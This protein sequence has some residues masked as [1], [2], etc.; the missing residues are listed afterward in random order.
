MFELSVHRLG[1]LLLHLSIVGCV[2]MVAASIVGRRRNDGRLLL[3]GERAGYAVTGA[4]LASAALLVHSFLSHDY[5]NKYVAHYSDNNMPWYYLIASFWGGQAGSLMFWATTLAVVT[6]IVIWQNREQN[7]DIL[8][9]VIASLGTMQV[10]FL[11]LMVREANPFDA[12]LITE[13]PVNGRGLEPLLQ[14]PA[15]TFHP[16]SILSGYVWFSVPFAFAIASLVHRRLDDG[17]IR[18]TRRYAVVSWA[19]LSIGNLF[20]GM[21]AYQ[22]L[23][24]GGF[25][26]WD[27]VENAALMPWISATAYLHSVMIQERRGLLKVWNMF[28]VF[29]TGF[30][31]LFGTFLTRAGVID[32]VHTFAQSDVGD[33]F[34]GALAVVLVFTH[35]LLVA[36]VA[37]GSLA[38]GDDPARWVKAYEQAGA[39]K[40]QLAVGL[41]VGLLV[42][43]YGVLAFLSISQPS[44]EL[45]AG[46][47]L[48]AAA[49]LSIF[50]LPIFI[51]ITI[52]IRWAVLRTRT[53]ANAT[54][55][56]DL[57][58]RE[59]IFLLN[60][61][62]LISI[63]AV[64]MFG[65]I[66]EK[67]SEFFWQPT[68][69]SA[70]WYNAWIAPLGVGLILLMGVGPLVP[71][72]RMSLQAFRKNLLSPAIFAL[73]C[74]GLIY[75]VNLYDLQKHV[76]ETSFPIGQVPVG[77]LLHASK[78]T[79][80]YT[81]LGFYGVFFSVLTLGLEFFRGA[82]LRMKSTSESFPVA[83]FGLIAKGRRR[84]GGYMAHIGFA[85][86]FLGF[87]GTGLKT[88][89]DMSFAAEGTTHVIRD[90]HLTFTGF[91][92]QENREYEEWFAR[93][94][95]RELNDDGTAGE[96]IGVLFPS[97]RF[98]NGA[99]V[100]LSR[101][102]TEKDELHAFRGNLYLALVSFRPGFKSCEIMAHFNP[103]IVWMWIG[104][105]LLLFGVVLSIWPEP[106]PYPVF[107]AA[108]RRARKAAPATGEA[109]PAIGLAAADV[110][111]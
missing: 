13:P 18:T 66:G 38:P 7:R 23:G 80:V 74:V 104:G 8:P 12:F 102:T 10:F 44:A 48:I 52:L 85:G 20:G 70:P 94:E 54:G 59:G 57:A 2:F 49:F 71:W 79:G 64:V 37:D 84:Y 43:V 81:L 58:S 91:D 93:F 73:A 69:Y 16:P 76:A 67:V 89:V 96:Q 6:G 111:R 110:E 5:Q 108:R 82:R 9:T 53:P 51:G 88:E 68:K 24:W 33:Y 86:L 63:L 62:I 15:M 14:N 22:E 101:A 72:R 3:A 39:G 60:N 41:S 32:S 99:N 83:L 98:Y 21:W 78:L 17:W 55:I 4:V 28:L 50:G 56:E 11:I 35:G 34:V 77:Q 61:Y 106:Q 40:R 100:T 31:T 27:P 105:A 109:A 75:S 95:I 36:R 1:D 19:F 92:R 30:L 42:L 107:S 25:W 45:R 47:W 103:M 65:T 90:K 26:G 97:R 29:L 87:I 46:A